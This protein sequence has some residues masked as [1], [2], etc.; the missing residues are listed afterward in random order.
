MIRSA[1]VV[2]AVV[3]GFIWI[4]GGPYNQ[5]DRWRIFAGWALLAWA[6]FNIPAFIKGSKGWAKLFLAVLFIALGMALYN[7]NWALLETFY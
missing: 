4:T 5:D 2:V 6:L 7:G 1:L 3:T